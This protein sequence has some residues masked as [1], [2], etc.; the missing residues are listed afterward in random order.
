MSNIFN[1]Y[2]NLPNFGPIQEL[3][4]TVEDTSE[5]IIDEAIKQGASLVE[6]RAL[7]Q[8]VILSVVNSFSEKRLRKQ[9]E[10]KKKARIKEGK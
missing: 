6:L 1:E 4:R 5:D 7:E 2:G 8:H 10:M 9:M 3:L